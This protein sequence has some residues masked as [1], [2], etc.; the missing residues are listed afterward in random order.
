MPKRLGR[1]DREHGAPVTSLEPPRFGL[2]RC[3]AV[4]GLIAVGLVLWSL[5]GSEPPEAAA[6]VRERS[7]P[8]RPAPPISAPVAVPEPLA[9]QPPARPNHAP[10]ITSA[11]LDRTHLCPGESTMLRMTAEDFDDTDLRYRAIY[12]SAALGGPRFGFGRWLRFVAPEAPG[13]YGL[14]AVVED[15]SRAR[16]EAELVV[17]VD[18]CSSR[19]P[20]DAAQLRIVHTELDAMVH[21]FDLGEARDRALEAGKALEVRRWYFGDGTTAEGGLSVRHHY[22]VVLGRRYSYYLV[23]VDVHVD[24][25]PA[26]IEYGLS[27]YSYAAANLEAG[28]VALAADVERGDDSRASI[29][30]VVT[31]SNLTPFSASAAEFEVVCFDAAGVP[32]EKWRERLDLIVPGETSMEQT[33]QLDRRRCPGGASYE[34]FGWA[35]GGY[36]VGGLWSYRLRPSAHEGDP[37]AARAQARLVLGASVPSTVP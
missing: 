21:E 34:L 7:A 37:R 16:D 6:T 17:V 20:L 36:A 5:A 4:C 32:K 29:D 27:F 28:Y 35:D 23:Q 14:V 10:R 30:Y 22:P 13:T 15:P 31:F 9:P 19:P 8:R 11:T 18:E 26:R 2:R 3:I 25:V 33:L 1:S 24:G 12:L